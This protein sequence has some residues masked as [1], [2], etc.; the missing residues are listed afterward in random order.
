[1]SCFGFRLPIEPDITNVI[2]ISNDESEA[3]DDPDNSHNL[4]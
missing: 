3:C 2:Y 1:M 4:D